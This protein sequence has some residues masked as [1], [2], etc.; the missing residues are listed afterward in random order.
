MRDQ[1]AFYGIAA[2]AQSAIAKQAMSGLP[3][4]TEH[5]LERIGR[6]CWKRDEREWQYFA[7]GYLRRHINVATCDFI[8]VAESLITTKSWWDTVDSLASRTVGPLV[9]M[10]P[11]L[12]T[13]MDDWIASDNIWLARTAILH[14]LAYK[15]ATDADRL[16][17]YC[18]RRAGDSEFFI[19]KAI[20]WALREYT[21]TDA[22]AVKRFLAQ[23]GDSL[24]G[25]SRTEAMKWLDR[26]AARA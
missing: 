26:R 17:A 12:V 11:H 3:A 25:L 19:R 6:A 8:A 5:E 7:C 2:P 1:F 18:T 4:P 21:K 22:V 23:H 13:V 16:F 10:H 15:S 9:T 20:G 24:S 14:Q